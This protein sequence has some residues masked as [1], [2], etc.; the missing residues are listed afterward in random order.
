LLPLYLRS[1]TA[2]RQIDTEN[3]ATLVDLY[4]QF[5][6]GK[7]RLF[8][9]FRHPSA[10]DPLC[11]A[12]LLWK[13]VPK[14]AK[15]QGIQLEAPIHAHFMYDRGI[16][17][18]AGERM[19]WLYSQLGGTPIHRGKIDLV[20]LRSARDLF[21][22]GQYPLAAAPEGAT[23]GHSEVISPLEPGI[24]QLAFWAVE[25]I[26]K[27]GRS[28]Q[29]LILPIG[30][31]Y[32]YITP[33]W[34][35]LEQ[36]LTGLEHD[37]GVAQTTAATGNETELYERLYQ[38]GGHLLV[39]M[40]EFYTRFYH[41]AL[42]DATS[43]LPA[44]HEQLIT[45]LN[46]LLDVALQVA[47]EYFGLSAKGTFID[48]CR[49]LEQAGWDYIY[50]D[51]LKPETISALDRG[52]ADRVAE[53]ADLRVWHMRIVESFV[54][55]TGNYV[56]EKPSAERFA[57]T[58]LLMWDMIARIKGESP[59][60]RPKLG[61]QAAVVTIGHPLSVSER[62]ESYQGGR[63]NA[64]QAVAELTQTLQTELEQLIQG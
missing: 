57:E 38:L 41:R 16:P 48:R 44:S 46:T 23:N 40:E 59:F 58:A 22:N 52:L 28:E 2:L 14:V 3:V 30:I 9:A 39:K 5:Q 8:L 17:L 18:W 24:S 13:A 7:N 19:G 53:E 35:A 50:R 49:R 15:Q 36:L 34:A 10:D 1:K 63:R 6:A 21:V 62:W 56:R 25:D 11:L 4:H 45:R 12:H 47:E 61:D 37:I 60:N 42:P 43:E 51:D 54:A 55:V 31:K 20:G 27:A 33:P 29:V 64:K 26:R 32:R